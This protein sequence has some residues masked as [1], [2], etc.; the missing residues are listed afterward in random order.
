MRNNFSFYLTILVIIKLF[1]L[2][3]LTNTYAAEESCPAGKEIA[4]V[5][6]KPDCL[7]SCNLTTD[8]NKY[9][10]GAGIYQ[11]YWKCCP[12]DYHCG[13]TDSCYQQNTDRLPACIPPCY[14][15]F[16]QDGDVDIGDFVIFRNCM[17]SSKDSSPLSSKCEKTDYN[18]DGVVNLEDLATFD[19]VFNGPCKKPKKCLERLCCNPYYQTPEGNLP[20]SSCEDYNKVTGNKALQCER[21]CA[22]AAK[23][24]AELYK[25]SNP[26]IV[27]VTYRCKWDDKKNTCSFSFK[28]SVNNTKAL[29]LSPES[30][31]AS[32]CEI[33]YVSTKA[34]EKEDDY[35]EVQYR[36]RNLSGPLENCADLMCSSD[37]NAVC[38]MF[39]P[40]P[41]PVQ[42][43]FFGIWNL[44]SGLILIFGIYYLTKLNLKKRLFNSQNGKKRKF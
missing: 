6:D 27:I 30:L 16:N 13:Y 32:D 18:C 44:L 12:N 29:F 31:I 39:L 10:Y 3:S 2:I 34:C 22:N 38:T 23:N 8:K 7:D 20:I 5:N 14:G 21:D 40:C 28:S 15:D 36:V 25:L 35:R 1:F 33:S 43:H 19:S 4:Y 9:C 37:T 41:K 24:D 42:L 11:N 17:T 26:E